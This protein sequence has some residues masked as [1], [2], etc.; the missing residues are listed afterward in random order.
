GKDTDSDSMEAAENR[1]EKF[2][3]SGSPWQNPTCSENKMNIP[4]EHRRNINGILTEDI[5][6]TV[7]TSDGIIS[8][9]VTST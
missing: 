4:T 3:E 2:P 7:V 8:P 6:G 9:S 5:N 1:S